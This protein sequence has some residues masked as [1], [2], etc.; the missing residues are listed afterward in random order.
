MIPAR[1][2]EYVEGLVSRYQNIVSNRAIFRNHEIGI[3]KNG[4]TLLKRDLVWSAD[5]K[6][7]CLEKFNHFFNI[8][9][10]SGATTC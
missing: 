6:A 1:R 5:V 9:N 8:G 4:K 3:S 2:R 7:L 10:A